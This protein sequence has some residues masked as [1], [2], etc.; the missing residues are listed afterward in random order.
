ME[1]FCLPCPRCPARRSG[2]G[3]APTPGIPSGIRTPLQ[4][5]TFSAVRGV[6][7]GVPREH[8]WRH[9]TR[10]NIVPACQE[11][12]AKKQGREWHAYLVQRA[13]VDVSERYQRVTDF[14][15]HYKYDPDLSQLRDIA[16]E[17]YAEVGTLSM[18]LATLK[19][20]RAREMV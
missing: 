15:R 9:P 8:G 10:L 5:G 18:A 19:V 6:R 14:V 1:H 12:N 4:T 20:K 17:L 3:S 11:C 2:F 7:G 16:G 13:G